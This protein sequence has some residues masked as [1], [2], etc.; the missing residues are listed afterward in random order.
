MISK[1]YRINKHDFK[2]E[3][4]HTC[5]LF[6]YK[7][8]WIVL[9]KKGATP[10]LLPVVLSMGGWRRVAAVPYSC[11]RD[12]FT[13]KETLEIRPRRSARLLYLRPRS[14]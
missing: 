10:K 8:I 12:L 14:T 13:A 5:T 9:C 6:V 3:F 4:R 2:I 1:K 11:T 7:S